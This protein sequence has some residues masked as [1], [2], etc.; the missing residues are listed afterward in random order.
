[1]LQNQGRRPVRNNRSLLSLCLAHKGVHSVFSCPDADFS[2]DGAAVRSVLREP[3]VKGIN[4][5]PRAL[6]VAAS[7]VLFLLALISGEAMA[8][9]VQQSCERDFKRYCGSYEAYSKSGNACMR[10]MGRSH[11]LDRDCLRALDEGG[12]VTQADREA[13]RRRHH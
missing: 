13:Y 3:A 10:S 8:L 7:L 12:Y 4:M 11:R 6:L 9:D 1:M 5:R 2:P